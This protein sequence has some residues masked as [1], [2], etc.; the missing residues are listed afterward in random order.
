MEAAH[1]DEV[2]E[3]WEAFARGENH[4]VPFTFACDEQVWLQVAGQ[5][6]ASFYTDP[7][8]HLEAQLAGRRWLCEQVRHDAA[9]GLPD[10]WTVAVQ[11][12]MEENEYF[13]SPAVLQEDDYA[14]SPPLSLEPDDLLHHLADLDPVKCVQQSHAY[15]LWQDLRELCDGRT[16]CDR[17]I[18]VVPP[19]GGTHGIFTKAAE[20]RGLERL[21]VDL[22]DRPAFVD[23]LLRLVTEKTLGRMQAWGQLTGADRL[24][25][26][27]QS[28]GFADDSLQLLS[29][30]AYRRFVLPWHERFF[31][32]VTTGPRWLHLCGHARQHYEI[33]HRELGIGLLD[34]PGPFVD[35]AHYLEALGPQFRFTA[36]TDHA[37]LAQGPA[38]AIEAMLRRLLRPGALRAGCFQV[39]AYLTRA[40]PLEHVRAANEL[41]RE[42]GRIP[43]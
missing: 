37:V 4:R 28:F 38:S 1:A 31:R 5:S 17:P 24:I 22:T 23:E 14:W 6:F 25:P 32:A 9:P 3:L 12:W 15:R 10:R 20:I 11:Y 33:L 27:D 30:A 43:A 13:G 36:Q 35:H 8:I 41:A 39:L 29:P 21:C 18:D 7:R 19:G 16:W 42:L 40:T 26:S 2:R 34:G